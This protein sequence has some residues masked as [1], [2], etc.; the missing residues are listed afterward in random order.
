MRV[1]WVSDA[2]KW[3]YLGADGAMRTGWVRDAD[4]WYLLA[5][6]GGSMLTGTVTYGGLQWVFGGDGALIS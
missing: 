5:G 2:G 3:Y 1:G 6:P 4:N